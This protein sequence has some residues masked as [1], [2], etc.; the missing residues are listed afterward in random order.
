MLTEKQL[1]A[2]WALANGRSDVE[3][4]RAAG[5]AERTFYRWKQTDKFT[6]A[7]T[8][9]SRQR[10][11][12]TAAQAKEL[13]SLASARGDEERALGYQ[14]LLVGELGALSVDLIRQIRAD[15]IENLGPRYVG[16]IIKAFADS[17]GM[18]QATGDRLIGLESL[19]ADVA[20]LEK[21][22]LEK[23]ESEPEGREPE[24]GGGGSTA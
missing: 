8:F 23:T 14:R 16:P 13:V 18:L 7:V 21:T 24:G 15:G 11:G 9:L 4:I 6:E 3:A 20:T 12:K 1:R 10:A 2:A 19:I 22:L 17:V 5:V